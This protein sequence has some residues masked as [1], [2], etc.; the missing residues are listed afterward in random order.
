[1]DTLT[2]SKQALNKYVRDGLLVMG[3]RVGTHKS[4]VL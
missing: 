1:M 2:V 4:V 3:A